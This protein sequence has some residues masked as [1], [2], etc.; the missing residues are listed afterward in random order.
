[1]F[2]DTSSLGDDYFM[3]VNRWVGYTERPCE[4][5]TLARGRYSYRYDCLTGEFMDTLPPNGSFHVVLWPGEGRLYRLANFLKPNLSGSVITTN[6]QKIRLSWTDPNRNETSYRVERKLSSQQWPPSGAEIGSTN[7]NVTSYYDTNLVGSETYNYRVRASDEQYY[8]E[9]SNEI[10]VKNIPNPP[11]N[12]TAHLNR[13]CCPGR[14][15]GAGSG[16]GI[17]AICPYCYTNKIILSWQEP[18]N[19]KSGTL[20]QYK[21]TATGPGLPGGSQS[22]TVPDEYTS[23]T[24]C[25][26]ELGQSYSF[27]VRAIDTSGNQSNPSNTVNI[28]SGTTDNCGGGEPQTKIV[29][30]VIPEKFELFQNYP[31][32]FNFGTLIKYALPEESEVKIV[33]YNLLG[34]KVRVLV[35]DVQEPGYYTIS[36]NG[37]NDN[38]ETVGSGI[39]FYRIQAGSFSKT[40]KMSLL[41]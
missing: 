8:S 25:V 27:T 38:S 5:V 41:K 29:A 15:S 2:K 32:P 23:T 26:P 33:V 11:R 1:M 18:Q 35:E 28:T 21:I 22:H 9:Y 19:Q 14:G 10:T 13:I 34:Q 6:P 7:A 16:V 24:F 4:K 3:L 40:A 20:T 36:W 37:K 39:Y 12:L 31:N 17:D 30:Q